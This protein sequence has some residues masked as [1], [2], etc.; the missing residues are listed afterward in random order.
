M[1]LIDASTLCNFNERS[2]LGR[3]FQK[4][5]W[6]DARRA[7]QD[8]VYRSSHPHLFCRFSSSSSSSVGG[9]LSCGR[10]PCRNLITSEPVATRQSTRSAPSPGFGADGC[11]RDRGDGGSDA[12][13]MRLRYGEHRETRS[14]LDE[15][16][17]ELELVSL[18]WKHSIARSWSRAARPDI[19]RSLKD[20][21]VI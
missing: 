14:H 16:T 1:R 20:T 2:E 18:K 13:K 5:P 12:A 3:I 4:T 8:L 11:G 17:K 9:N 10:R 21:D 15:R 7:G 19:K 6:R